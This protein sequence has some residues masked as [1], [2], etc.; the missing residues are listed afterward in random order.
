[1]SEPDVGALRT[2]RQDLEHTI[3]QIR[4]VP[5]YGNFLAS[6]AFGDVAA[7][8]S[9]T[10]IVYL[11]AA[12]PGGLALIVRDDDVAHV[13]LDE[14]TAAELRE[15][16]TSHFAVYADY[17]ADRSRRPQWDRSLDEIT[18]WL[19]SVAMGPVLAELAGCIETVLVPGGLL[20]LLPLHAA[21]TDDRHCPTGRRYALDELAISYTPSV[22]ALAVARANARERGADRALVLAEPSPVPAGP[23][24]GARYEAAVVGSGFRE[25]TIL[26]GG[27]ATRRAFGRRAAEA[28]V[29]HLACHGY[30]DLIDP[31]DSGLLVAG[32]RIT[33]REFLDDYRLRV[34]LAVLSACETGLPG[35]DL[36]D[37]VVAL[38]TGLVQ[39]GVAGIVASGWSV[40]DRATAMLMAEFY[41]QWARDGQSPGQALRKAQQW[42]RDTT[43]QAKRQHWQRLA[44]TP[45]LP[46]EV[47]AQFEYSTVGSDRA[48][49]E[50]AGIHSWG[51]FAHVGA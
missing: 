46:P 26:G 20:G 19:W 23:L 13:T 37:E 28:D 48:G 30:A 25:T 17:R 2:A 21:W 14:M 41:R 1:M 12:E 31:L 49:R 4:D 10:P 15:R 33:L 36:P 27:S 16:V 3:G 43:T 40:P 11:A 34:R 47:A 6:P 35:T 24:P 29:L 5:G 9:A 8:A 42:L 39:A 18:G 51:A 22:R 7:Q 45:W 38:P 32:G 44:G 50:H